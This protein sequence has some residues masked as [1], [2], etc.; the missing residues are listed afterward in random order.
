MECRFCGAEILDGASDCPV[1]K[2]SFEEVLHDRV[3]PGCGERVAHD[4]KYCP[5]CGNRLTAEEAEEVMDASGTKRKGP[6]W[7][8]IVLASAVC[9]AVIVSWRS[10][11]LTAGS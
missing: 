10:H 1:C 11:C 2:R 5:K 7:I 4:A 8:I 9:I 6:K 3:C